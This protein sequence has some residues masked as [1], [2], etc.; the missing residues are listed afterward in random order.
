MCALKVRWIGNL[1]QEVVTRQHRLIVD[2][3]TSVGGDDAGPDPYEL[4]LGALGSCTAMTVLLYAKRREWQ[5]EWLEVTLDQDRIHASECASCDPKTRP[6][7]EIMRISLN[8]EVH[9]DLNEEQLQRLR[10]VAKLCPVRRTLT[11][12]IVVEDTLVTQPV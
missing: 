10:E 4:I 8:L 7:Q 11:G 5:I 9:G 1:K 6:N 3:P 12:E 2:E